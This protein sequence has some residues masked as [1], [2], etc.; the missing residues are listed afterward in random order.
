MKNE[1]TDNFKNPS[2]AYRGKPFWAWNGKLEEYELRR[3]IRVMQEMGLGGGFMHS[4]I[5]LDTAYLSEEWF[6]L[7]NACADECEKLKMEAW[8][9]DEDR[10]P[11]GAAGGLVTKNPKYRL[12]ALHITI[13]ESSGIYKN[14]N[15]LLAVFAAKIKDDSVISYRKI[16]NG[17]KLEKDEKVLEFEV[18]IAENSPW[19]N[20]YTYLDTMSEE[21]V[22]KFIEVTHLAYAKNCKKYFSKT[23]P[24]IFT[25]EPNYGHIHIK[26]EKEI[27]MTWTDKLPSFF[28]RHYGYN[29][30]DF[31]PELVVKKVDDIFSKPRHDYFEACT[32]LFTANF[33]KQ[34]YEWC[35]KNKI[36]FTGHVLSEQSLPNQ[37]AVVGAAMRFYPYMQAPGI[38]ILC[39]QSLKRDGG[40]DPEYLTAKQ[41]SSVVNQ[42]GRKWM[43]SEL[44]G[45]TGWNFTFAEH[46]A[47]GDWQA[48]LGVNLRCQHLS[49][50][51]MEGEAKRDY[52]ASIF[53]Q[54][55]WWHDYPFVE[56]YFSRINVVM[57]EGNPVRD[58]A[59][60]HPIES[61]WGISYQELF[62]T[63]KNRDE[64]HPINKLDQQLKKVQDILLEEHFDFDYIDEEILAT[65]GSAGKKKLKVAKASYKA[66]IVPP[67]YTIRRKT[68]EILKRFVQSGGQVLFVGQI[69]SRVEAEIS[70]EVRKFAGTVKTVKLDRSEIINSIKTF[71]GIRRVSIKTENG[72]EYNPAL[73]ML[74]EDKKSACHYLFV[75]NTV[76]EEKCVPL[77]IEVPVTGFI[78]ELDAVKGQIYA[79]DAENNRDS[80]IIKT[81]LNGCGSR[82]F[83]IGCEKHPA[84]EK[85][86]EYSEKTTQKISP[87]KW[88]IQRDEPNA[89][90]LDYAEY[91]IDG[92]EWQCP[93]EILKI[94]RELRAYMGI[95]KRGGTMC[96]PWA[97]EK[98]KN[99][100]TARISLKYK[101][102]TKDI[103]MSPC[104]LVMEHPEKFTIKLNGNELRYDECEG[105]WIDTS[106]KKIK[107]QPWLLKNGVNELFLE[108][109]YAEKDNLEA[110][111]FTGEFALE[112]EK[113]IPVISQ[114]P[115]ELS[116]GDWCKSGFSSYTGSMTYITEFNLE[117]TNN[118]IF[119]TIPSWKGALLKVRI[120]G[121]KAGTL[122]W[123]PFEIDITDFVR[124]G[125]NFLEIEVVG[126]RRNLLG[127]LHLKNIYPIWT[128]PGQF[129]SEK[130]EWTDEYVLFEY[131]LMSDPKLSFRV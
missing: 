82:L 106:F 24:G 86:I 33:A 124:C 60:L 61:A 53:F 115:N 42:F 32:S 126:T 57:T 71:D 70:D 88:K 119:L 108:T 91:S 98:K 43:L 54:S 130:F 94:D 104:H 5:G 128:G 47:V 4:R 1:M 97:I 92:G 127:P 66:I 63:K 18:K 27:I 120:N 22:K 46:K 100:K 31:L 72:N 20:G 35:K 58:I 89:F 102:M 34:I 23:I 76:Q 50:F 79:A 65:Y 109:N 26:S 114:V 111:Y 99:L 37:T 122:A 129:V 131:G 112:R 25:D 80:T 40:C 87:K 44:Y 55:P 90:P 74:R 95:P 41:C 12:R 17:D 117:K 77:Q 78:S 113:S 29:L 52:P 7:I 10:W 39:G 84:L 67:A 28:K 121:K 9:Y 36:M 6:K 105:W 19:Y 93:M 2:S 101:F 123:P 38:D 15:K 21:A 59:V 14:N 125:E 51:T 48:A 103:P 85:N 68:F 30:L 107:V 62:G 116:T 83:V 75:C 56:D 16:K 73:Y 69:P 45:C 64:Q 110:L 118:K 96:Q 3:Q 81:T 13:S 49:W 11:S 8:L